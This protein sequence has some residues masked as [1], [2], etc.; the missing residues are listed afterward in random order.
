M[1]EKLDYEKKEN[2]SLN[3]QFVQAQ[4]PKS[5]LQ[6]ILCMQIS[7]VLLKS[8]KNF[9][10]LKT[11]SIYRIYIFRHYYKHG[12][13]G[14]NYSKPPQKNQFSFSN[15]PPLMFIRSTPKGTHM[16]ILAEKTDEC[17]LH[18]KPLFK[19]E[20]KKKRKTFHDIDK[21]MKMHFQHTRPIQTAHN[22]KY[23]QHSC[24]TL[25]ITENVFSTADLPVYQQKPYQGV[26][27]R[28][29]KK[30][31][32]QLKASMVAHIWMKLIR[33]WIRD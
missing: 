12:N 18:I 27:L 8:C 13:H 19:K 16:L 17:I 22:T 21:N 5:N 11:I 10:L 20:E 3:N 1:K 6:P 14:N 4:S 31:C 2:H 33:E 23:L 9:L 29:E 25:V 15:C 28:H 24:A 32:V 30:N 7:S 26:N